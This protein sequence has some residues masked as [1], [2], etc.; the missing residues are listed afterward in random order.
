MS[1]IKLYN[2]SKSYKNKTVL[3]DVT[4]EFNSNNI[5]MIVGGNGSGKSTLLKIIIGLIKPD[6]GKVEKDKLKIGYVP[7]RYLLPE[8]IKIKEYLYILGSIRKVNKNILNKRIDE[9]LK[10]WELYDV[11][12]YKLKQLSK[13][14][15]QKVVILQAL[16]H[17]PDVYIF[18]E[19]LNGLDIK[20]QEKLIKCIYNLKQNNKIIIITSHYP[21][22]YEEFV[23]IVYEID[24]FNLKSYCD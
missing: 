4:I 21:K 7:E 5:Y 1:K 19:A 17:D 12:E 16:I 9:L 2:I 8:Y 23:D 20:M 3:K 10:E 11:K 18:D 6:Y 24:N 22:M 13:G 15:L 14:M